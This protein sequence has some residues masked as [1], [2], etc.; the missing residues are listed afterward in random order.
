MSDIRLLD[1][2]SLQSHITFT[3]K[4]TLLMARRVHDRLRLFAYIHASKRWVPVPLF[5]RAG[6]TLCMH[7]CEFGIQ[8]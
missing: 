8:I 3:Y 7:L 4:R 1:H 5:G 2:N 6:R